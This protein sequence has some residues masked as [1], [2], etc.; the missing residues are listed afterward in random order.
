MHPE[1]RCVAPMASAISSL[2][3]ALMAPS[4]IDAWANWAKPR[5]ASDCDFR[6]GPRHELMSWMSPVWSNVLMVFGKLLR[7]G[8]H[9]RGMVRL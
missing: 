5:I 1:Q 8:C 3:F 4:A 2:C 6:N 9:V 7:K